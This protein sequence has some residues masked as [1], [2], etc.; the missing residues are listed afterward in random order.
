[1]CG[2]L[3]VDAH[4]GSTQH[5][6]AVAL[7]LRCDQE[8]SGV[9]GLLFSGFEGQSVVV[10]PSRNLVIVRLGLSRVPSSWEPEPFLAGVLEAVG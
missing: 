8:I 2:E 7:G 3:T 1:M 10:I 6:A 9:P 5:L 4:F